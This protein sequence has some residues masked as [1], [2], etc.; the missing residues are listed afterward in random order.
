MF[1]EKRTVALV[2][3]TLFIYAL[4]IFLEHNYFV[5]P[6]PIFD[7]VLVIISIQFSLWNFKDIIT[8][9]KWYFYIYALSLLLKVLTNP[10]FW[11]FFLNEIELENFLQTF[12][13]DYFK[14]GFTLSS[15]LVFFIWSWVEK[16]KFNFLVPFFIANTLLLGSFESTYWLNYLAFPAFAIYVTIQKPK[17]SLSYLLVLHGILDLMTLSILGIVH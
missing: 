15:I 4:N 5:F 10:I 8:F 14:I 17:N 7:F 16:L 1:K 9:R 3:L 11:G 6:F 2:V 13:M 12:W